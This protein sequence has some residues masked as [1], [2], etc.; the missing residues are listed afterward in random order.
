MH[1]NV[2]KLGNEFIVFETYKSNRQRVPRQEWQR[3]VDRQQRQ[4][5]SSQK[6][7]RLWKG[8]TWQCK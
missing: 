8:E 1:Q 4:K 2:T 3:P 6:Q 5:V 7:W